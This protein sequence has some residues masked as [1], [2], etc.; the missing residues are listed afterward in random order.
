MEDRGDNYWRIPSGKVTSAPHI[1]SASGKRPK[2]DQAPTWQNDPKE[3]KGN[4]VLEKRMQMRSRKRNDIRHGPS[5][6]AL[7]GRDGAPSTG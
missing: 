5:G 2:A 3:V 7:H 6:P 4:S 1:S